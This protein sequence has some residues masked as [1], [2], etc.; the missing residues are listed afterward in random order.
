MY[1]Q[2]AEY[3]E[4]L[5]QGVGCR[6]IKYLPVVNDEAFIELGQILFPR[7]PVAALKEKLSN[8]HGVH[9]VSLDEIIRSLVAIA[10]TRWPQK[11]FVGAREE[12]KSSIEGPYHQRR[13]LH[14]ELILKLKEGFY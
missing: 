7:H 1:R 6:I 3:V 2:I 11:V 14:G 8:A 5:G 4:T 10:L 13:I 12:W 9:G